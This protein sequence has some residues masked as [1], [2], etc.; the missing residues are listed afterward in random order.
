MVVVLLEPL[1]WTRIS[2]RRNGSGSGSGVEP[3]T[4]TI[5]V[6]TNP[7]PN[8]STFNVQYAESD[9]GSVWQMDG[10]GAVNNGTASGTWVCDPSTP[11]CSGMSGTFTA[12]Q[13]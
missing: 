13:Q 7:V 4:F 2:R 10:T 3:L 5:G 6:P 8:G 1:T 12:A 11:A 9:N